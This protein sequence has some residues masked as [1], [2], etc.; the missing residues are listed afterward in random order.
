MQDYDVTLKHGLTQPGSAL[1]AAL[2]SSVIPVEPGVRWLNVEL[3]KVSNPR[4]DLLG[5]LPDGRLLHFEFQSRNQKDLVRRMGEYLFAI[6]RKHGRIPA[7]IVLYVGEEPMR[8][9]KAVREEGLDFRFHMVDVRELDGEALLASPNLSD[10]VV[11]VLTGLGDEPGTVRRILERIV[12]A[13]V[14]ERSSALME[15]SILAGLRKLTGEVK[16]EAM[17]MPVT[18]DILDNEI[19]GVPFRQGRAEGRVEGRVEGLVEGLLELLLDQIEN[20]FGAVPPG[21]RTRLAALNPAQLRAAGLRLLNAA[22]IED[23]FER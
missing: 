19:F 9:E 21:F 4:V 23:L 1:L 2:T 20:R 13:P 15:L 22:S 17:K 11:A 14:G 12:A 3:P 16:Q 6:W 18:E 8:M 5:A 10:N 7:Q